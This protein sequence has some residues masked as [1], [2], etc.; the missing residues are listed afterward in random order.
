M[1]IFRRYDQDAKLA[2]YYAAHF[3]PQRGKRS[4]S[5]E[6]L[7][8]GLTWRQHA[9]ECEFRALKEHSTEIWEHLGVSHL[10]ISSKPWVPGK[11]QLD[12]DAKRVLRIAKG[13]PTNTAII[14][15]M[16]ITCFAP[17]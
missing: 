11:L 4:I 2:V 9:N 3:A 16:W 6:E 10:P 1:G 12:A 7:L 14:G 8:L 15:S 17:C 13:E 5:P